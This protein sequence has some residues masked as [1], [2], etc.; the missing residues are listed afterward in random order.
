M[1]SRS[2]AR[3]I[4]ASVALLWTIAIELFAIAGCGGTT[5]R[6]DLPISASPGG[7]AAAGMTT[8]GAATPEVDATMS[9][10]GGEQGFDATIMYADAAR[11]PHFDLDAGTDGGEAGAGGWQSWPVCPCDSFASLEGG[12]SAGTPPASGPCSAQQIVWTMR[13]AC[14]QCIRQNPKNVGNGN[15][16]PPCCDLRD[17]GKAAAG[18]E[19][20]QPLF[21]LCADLYT[22]ARDTRCYQD[23]TGTTAQLQACYCGDAGNDA[24]KMGHGNGACKSQVEAAFQVIAGSPDQGPAWALMNLTATGVATSPDY[25][26][27]SAM[28]IVDDFRPQPLTDFA[29]PVDCPWACYAAAPSA[30]AYVPPAPSVVIDGGSFTKTESLLYLASSSCYA[31]L[32]DFGCLDDSRGDMNNECEDLAGQTVPA[33]ADAGAG[34]SRQDLCY[35]TLQCILGSPLCLTDFGSFFNSNRCVAGADAGGCLTQEENG[36]E[37]TDPALIQSQFNDSTRGAGVANRILNCGAAL[38]C[39]TCFLQ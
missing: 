5:G 25:T 29:Y 24:C 18:P 22:K 21:N 32:K 14:D 2:S 26:G 4:V 19:A 36:L 34:Q 30:S 33:G 6:G 35:A 23:S 8:D 17:A 16:F 3:R 31:C 12:V 11:L 7:D 15:P 28:S 10:D 37:T 27:G 39:P 20:T 13:P 1:K 9:E 38:N